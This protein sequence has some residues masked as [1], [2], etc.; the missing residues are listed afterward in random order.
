MSL[1]CQHICAAVSIYILCNNI[2]IYCQCARLAVGKL[3]AGVQVRSGIRCLSGQ[4]EGMKFLGSVLFCSVPFRPVPFSPLF[5]CPVPF[6]HLF[7]LSFYQFQKRRSHTYGSF[8]FCH[9]IYNYFQLV[10]QLQLSNHVLQQISVLCVLFIVISHIITYM[11][12]L[13]FVFLCDMSL[14]CGNVIHI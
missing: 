10:S 7:N 3:C 12:L 2:I 8:L 1:T 5:V 11:I 4:E 9:I 13:T 6:R 14:C